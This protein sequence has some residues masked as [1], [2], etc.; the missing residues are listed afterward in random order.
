MIYGLPIVSLSVAYNNR[1][2]EL[3]EVLFDTGCAATVFDTD[4]LA[5][6]DLYPDFLNG[7]VKRMYGLLEKWLLL[8]V[9]YQ[10]AIPR[11]TFA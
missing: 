4:V 10:K 8:S 5:S 1:T 3:T 2:I 6:I 7:T 9:Y 11:T